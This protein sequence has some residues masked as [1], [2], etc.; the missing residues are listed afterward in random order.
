M[1]KFSNEDK[2]MAAGVARAL[3]AG[4]H[5]LHIAGV[6]RC[7]GFGPSARAEDFQAAASRAVDAGIAEL[8]AFAA[9]NP[10]NGG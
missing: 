7:P 1:Q 3:G 10:L 2:V 8:E 9:S 5:A 4:L 6:I